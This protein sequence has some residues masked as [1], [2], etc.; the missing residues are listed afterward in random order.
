MSSRRKS[1]NV[2]WSPV[3][4]S[5]CRPVSTRKRRK[6]QARSRFTFL[7]DEDDERK[8]SGNVHAY[9]RRSTH[10]L[11]LTIR[12]NVHRDMQML[13]DMP[14][15]QIRRIYDGKRS[16]TVNDLKG[17]P[18]R[19]DCVLGTIRWVDDDEIR[20]SNARGFRLDWLQGVHYL[21][22]ESKASTRTR[23]RTHSRRSRRR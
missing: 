23:R 16:Y 11:L 20:K 12:N 10:S 2:T 9:A 6:R 19:V 22:V 18:L 1:K 4:T 21:M 3:V 7:T 17:Q 15:Q 5:V 13:V 8:I 14:A